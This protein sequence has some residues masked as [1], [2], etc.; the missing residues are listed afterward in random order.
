[1][2]DGIEPSRKGP[3]STTYLPPSNPMG[4]YLFSFIFFL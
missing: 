2:G 4:G 1:M 3:R